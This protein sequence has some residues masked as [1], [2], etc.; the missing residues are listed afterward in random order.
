ML[1]EVWVG[2][3]MPPPPLLSSVVFSVGTQLQ[4]N[5]IVTQIAFAQEYLIDFTSSPSARASGAYLV[6]L[7]WPSC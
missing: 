1:D 7:T 2:S 4:D 3:L 6:E 5:L